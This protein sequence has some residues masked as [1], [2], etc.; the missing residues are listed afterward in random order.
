MEVRIQQADQRNPTIPH[1]EVGLGSSSVSSRAENFD[2][3]S[4]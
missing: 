2:H 3:R 1:K 4:T